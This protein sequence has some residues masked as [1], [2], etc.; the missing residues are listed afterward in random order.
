[1]TLRIYLGLISPLYHPALIGSSLTSLNCPSTAILLRQ[2][3]CYLGNS[4][5]FDIVKS[6]ERVV[7]NSLFVGLFLN[8]IY[9]PN[10]LLAATRKNQRTLA[11]RDMSPARYLEEKLDQAP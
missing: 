11:P 10:A 9:R 7:P 4:S 8:M 5:S 2:S 3:V 6:K 1:M